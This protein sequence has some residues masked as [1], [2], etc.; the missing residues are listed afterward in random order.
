MDLRSG[1]TSAEQVATLLDQMADFTINTTLFQNLA[2]NF[3]LAAFAF[4]AR[5]RWRS[6]TYGGQA[7]RNDAV[8]RG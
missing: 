8:P 5:S 1:H 2:F 7:S 3:T 4:T 6:A